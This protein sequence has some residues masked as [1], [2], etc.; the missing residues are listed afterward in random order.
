MPIPVD[1]HVIMWNEYT[2]EVAETHIIASDFHAVT[3]FRDRVW[4]SR[5]G[6]R[7]AQM[8]LDIL[9]GATP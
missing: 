6:W 4:P 1:V 2:R 9:E 5:L 3:R 7:Q 8:D